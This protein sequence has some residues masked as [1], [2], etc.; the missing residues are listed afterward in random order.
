[1]YSIQHN[2]DTVSRLEPS[3]FLNVSSKHSLVLKDVFLLSETTVDLGGNLLN[4]KTL[5]VEEQTHV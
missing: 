2:A 3:P 1:M 4:L 5:N